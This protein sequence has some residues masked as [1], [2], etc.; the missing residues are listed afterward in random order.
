[1]IEVLLSHKADVNVQNVDGHTALMFAFNGRNQV[2]SLLDKYSE[3]ISED[4]D[5]STAVIRKA[6]ETHTAIVDL[7]ISNGADVTLKDK[8]GNLAVDFDHVPVKKVEPSSAI[9]EE[10]NKKATKTE[11]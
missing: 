6:L 11:L 9:G 1:V 8:K 4:K 3:F 2:A 10:G 5:N 7:L